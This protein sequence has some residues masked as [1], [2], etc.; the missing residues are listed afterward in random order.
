MGAVIYEFLVRLRL[1]KV[2]FAIILLRVRFCIVRFALFQTKV[3]MPGR[4]TALCDIIQTREYLRIHS[5]M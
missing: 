2:Q 5:I 4:Y 3:R 1:L